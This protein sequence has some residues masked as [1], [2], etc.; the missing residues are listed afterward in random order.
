[1]RHELADIIRSALQK[2]AEYDK[3]WGKR[4]NFS[5][6]AV[7]AAQQRSEFQIA[8]SQGPLRPWASKHITLDFSAGGPF[9]LP[10]WA[11]YGFF[12]PGE[13]GAAPGSARFAIALVMCTPG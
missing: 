3:D 1:M 2:T 7:W 13:F 5:K 10:F 11:V 6:T 4:T 9:F 12:E 8:E